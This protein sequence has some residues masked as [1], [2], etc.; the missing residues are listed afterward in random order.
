MWFWPWLGQRQR[1]SLGFMSMLQNIFSQ[2]VNSADL[3]TRKRTMIVFRA[4]TLIDSN[5][6]SHQ[7]VKNFQACTSLP[8]RSMNQFC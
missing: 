1:A 5:I 3:T 7:N 6:P 2:S 4:I 8:K